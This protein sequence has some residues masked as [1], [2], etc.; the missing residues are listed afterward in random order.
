MHLALFGPK[1]SPALAGSHSRRAE[2]TKALNGAARLLPKFKTFSKKFT[3]KLKLKLEL[4]L[5]ILDST[6]I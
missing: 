5:F 2:R 6:K 4:N 3:I 1:E